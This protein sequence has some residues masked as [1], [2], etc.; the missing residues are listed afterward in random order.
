MRAAVDV[1]IRVRIAHAVD[2]TDLS[3]EIEN[4]LPVLDEHVHRGL[5]ADVGD[6]DPDSIFEA[7]NVEPVAAVLGTK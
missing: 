4:D 3:G 5:V 6:V 1:Q 2:V 7:V